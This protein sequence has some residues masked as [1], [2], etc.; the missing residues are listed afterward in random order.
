MA[1]TFEGCPNVSIHSREIKY[2]LYRRNFAFA[3]CSKKRDFKR[4][5]GDMKSRI[6]AQFRHEFRPGLNSEVLHVGFLFAGAVY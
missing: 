1:V 3:L 4:L 6:G 2:I 5:G